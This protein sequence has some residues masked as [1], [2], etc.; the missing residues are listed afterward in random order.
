MVAWG[1]AFWKAVRLVAAFGIIVVA[2]VTFPSLAQAD[3][4]VTAPCSVVFQVQP[5]NAV[6]RQTITGTDY[7]PSAHPVSAEVVEANGAIDTSSSAPITISIARGPAKAQLLG[8]TTVDAVSGVAT[9]VNALTLPGNGYLL[10]VSSP[11]MTPSTSRPFN[12]N[13]V[14]VMCPQ[15]KSCHAQINTAV[16]DFGVTANPVV[17]AP[18]AATLSESVD[19]GTALRCSGY[20]QEDPNWWEFF[21]SSTNR[22]KTI[23]NTLI[24]PPPPKSGFQFCLGAPYDFVTNTGGRAPPG[25]LPDGTKG[26]IGLLPS[27]ARFPAGPCLK[28]VVTSGKN[29]ILTVDIP[30]KLAGDPW[31]RA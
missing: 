20:T 26:F 8:K 3:P 25:V 9:F 5:H 21:V 18:N 1:V 24:N 17:G 22:T 6:I 23:T 28:S 15:D 14:A 31:G 27:C 16:S 29:V 13:D 2:S 4:C 11:N 7:T 30:A 12:E 19:V 10:K